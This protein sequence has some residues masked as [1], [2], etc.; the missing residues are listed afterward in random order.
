MLPIME[1]RNRVDV[2]IPFGEGMRSINSED[3][4]KLART[5]EGVPNPNQCAW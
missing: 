4:L 2:G 5:V 3:G 1:G